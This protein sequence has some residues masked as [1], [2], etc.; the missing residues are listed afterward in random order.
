MGG[1]SK[2]T[3]STTYDP[4]MMALHNA[5]YQRAL[6]VANT[7]YTPYTGTLDLSAATNANSGLLNYKAP[8]VSTAGN[9]SQD[10]IDHYMNPYIDDVVDRSLADTDR[11]RQ[12]AIN[13]GQAQAM[14]AGA[15]GGSRHGVADSLTNRDYGDIA[16]NTAAGL[17]QSGFNNAVGWGQQ[18]LSRLLSA[19]TSNQQASIS[20]AAVRAQ[21]AAQA[22]AMAQ[23]SYTADRDNWLHAYQ[24]PFLR[25]GMLT[26]TLGA[27]PVGS[28][29]TTTSRQSPG[30]GSILGGAGSLMSG[31]GQMGGSFAGVGSAI[32]SVL[33]FLGL[34]DER[35]K[36]DIDTAGY[37]D[38]GR[39]WV[40][41]RHRGEPKDVKRL[42]LLA[43]ELAESEP[44]RVVRLPGGLLG[45]D[46]GGLI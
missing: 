11:S 24:D 36:T 35:T 19:D 25:Q 20:S 39:R 40:T 41:Y 5:N 44:E 6:G 14:S 43:Q 16:A 37:D 1:K 30:L 12:M 9:V 38:E 4:A 34:S 33:P 15:F 26:S 13:T 3:Q 17:R 22:A 46:Y 45:V 27:I 42:G 18:D 21:A 10:Q 8:T 31:I 2:Q 23:A 7:P 32:S 28:T 29:T